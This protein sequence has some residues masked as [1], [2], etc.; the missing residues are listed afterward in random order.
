M[1]TLKPLP[2]TTKPFFPPFPN[3]IQTQNPNANKALQTSLKPLNSVSPAM[4][5]A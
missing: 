5:Q 4:E 1:L 2:T 3:P